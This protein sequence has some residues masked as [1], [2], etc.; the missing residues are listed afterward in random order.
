MVTAHTYRTSLSWSGSTGS[1]YRDY[2]RAHR[3][4]APPASGPVIL[5]ADP[6]FR[7]DA[8]LLNPE[9]LVVM[10]ASSCQL[11]SFLAVAA[12]AGVDVVGYDDTAEG[13]M[14][15]GARPMRIERIRLAPVIRVAGGTDREQ[16]LELVARAH[17]ECYVAN[18]LT[19]EVRV[20]ATVVTG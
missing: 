11:L 20:D 4:E 19:S 1:G 6:H 10:A 14:S 17:D 7:G 15:D 8:D 16:V 5:S 13:E 18:S 2:P 3:A 12:L 9:Q